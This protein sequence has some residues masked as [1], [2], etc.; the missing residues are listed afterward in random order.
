MPIRGGCVA[1]VW[2]PAA[3]AIGAATTLCMVAMSLGPLVLGGIVDAAGYW[4]AWAVLILSVILLAP[5]LVRLP[6]RPVSYTCQLPARTDHGN[7]S[8]DYVRPGGTGG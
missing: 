1:L 6:V 7:T 3:S 8:A 5:M 2:A 4:L